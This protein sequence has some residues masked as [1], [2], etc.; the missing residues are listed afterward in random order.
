MA[1]RRPPT[2]G[3]A[4]AGVDERALQVAQ[5]FLDLIGMTLQPLEC[6]L[7]D[8]LGHLTVERDRRCQADQPSAILSVELGHINATSGV[9]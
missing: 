9:G 5:R 3:H 7:D 8:L 6:L 1:I 2:Q 4:D